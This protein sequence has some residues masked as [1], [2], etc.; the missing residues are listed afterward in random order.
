MEYESVLTLEELAD[1][2]GPLSHLSASSTKKFY[3]CPYSFLC[4]IADAPQG[5]KDDCHIRFGSAVHQFIERYYENPDEDLG[6][7]DMLE[8][9]S[10]VVTKTTM[11]K[12]NPTVQTFFAWEGA[13]HYRGLEVGKEIF[14]EENFLL[15]LSPDLPPI[16]GAVDLYVPSTGHLVDWKTGKG[17]DFFRWGKPYPFDY[18]LQGAIYNVF[19]QTLG[20]PVNE[21]EFLFMPPNRSGFVPT[22]L[23]ADWLV[24]VIDSMM[25]YV[26]RGIFPRNPTKLCGWCEYNATQCIAL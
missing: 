8:H 17:D 5:P 14:I 22:H 6:P 19:E 25:D 26:R 11:A 2:I 9:V 18:Y 20:R 4:K 12:L 10:R 1:R 16:K 23:G 15:E 3:K 24:E 7:T 21:I 13:H